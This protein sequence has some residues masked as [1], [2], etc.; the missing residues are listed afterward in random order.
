MLLGWAVRRLCSFFPSSDVLRSQDP[1]GEQGQ[2]SH[3]SI[4]AS[5]MMSHSVEIR[6]SI[7]CLKPHCAAFLELL[8]SAGFA[9]LL[10]CECSN[11]TL[12]CSL[13]AELFLCK[14]LWIFR[15]LCCAFGLD[16]SYRL[17]RA[18]VSKTFSAK[19]L[20]VA[21][22]GSSCVQLPI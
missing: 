10:N 20:P 21:S 15:G 3:F 7:C 8:T 14:M 13:L 5:M 2:Q 19:T 6:C 17:P 22:F 16:P 4:S 18:S 1:C 11:N 9:Y 12:T